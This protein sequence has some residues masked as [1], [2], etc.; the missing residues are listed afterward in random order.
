MK[1]HVMCREQFVPTPLDEV[2]SFFDRPENLGELTPGSLGFRILTPNPI[3]MK[4]GTVIDYVIRLFFLPLRWRTLITEY[5]PP[6][7]FVD[8]QSRGPYR[9]WIHRHSFVAA[10][11]GTWI[12]DE[13]RYELPFGCLGR[14]AHAVMVRRMLERIFAYREVV[15]TQR[16]G[17]G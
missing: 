4:S 5:D 15:I 16:F 13:I 6:H 14:L 7:G 9:R 2:F 11:D 12:R 8:E 17:S 1:L 3:E 10:R